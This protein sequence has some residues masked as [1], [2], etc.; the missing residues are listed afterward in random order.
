MH[1]SSVLAPSFCSGIVRLSGQCRDT[2]LRPQIGA[3]SLGCQRA[4]TRAWLGPVR[5]DQRFR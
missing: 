3:D 4:P 5:D 1:R 2:E